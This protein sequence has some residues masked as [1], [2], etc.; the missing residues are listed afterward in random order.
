MIGT[1]VTFV[2]YILVLGLIAWLLLYLIDYVPVPAPFNRVA[3]VVIMVV[4]VLILIL[5]L[6]QLV[7]IGGAG[8]P[9]LG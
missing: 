9:K 2:V 8:L 7:G 6:L 1:L 3:K 5:L 4:T